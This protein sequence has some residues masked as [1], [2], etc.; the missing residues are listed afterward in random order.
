[1]SSLPD[2]YLSGEGAGYA[3]GIISAGLDGIRL[4]ETMLTGKPAKRE[5]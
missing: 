5:K 4:A 1:M 2:L 3:G